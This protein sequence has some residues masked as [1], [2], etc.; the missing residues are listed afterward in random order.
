MSNNF[1]LKKTIR[2]LVSLLLFSFLLY[3]LLYLSTGDPALGV[4]QKMGGQNISKKMIEETRTKLGING[5]FLQQ[6]FRWLFSILKGDFGNSFITNV[7]VIQVINEKIWVTTKLLSL[8]FFF[9]FLVSITFGSI[10]GNFSPL[11]WVKQV[12]SIVLS[13]PIYWIAIFSIFLLGVKFRWFPFVGSST[14]L[15]LILPILVICL[16]EGSYLTK[17][18]SDLI[19]LVRKSERQKIAIFRGINWYYRFYYQLKEIVIP[20][21][22]LYGNSFIHLFG[23]TIMIEI[24]FSISG[25]GKLLMEAISARDYPVIQ[26]VTLLIAFGTFLFNYLIDIVIQ[27]ADARIQ[28]NGESKL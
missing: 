28:V 18:V 15:H 21:I 20:L 25:I 3:G 2:L 23:G 17:M 12:L 16:S 22:S 7:P 24:I 27:K 11:I 13:F 19:L 1:L 8:S 5:S 10:I 6:Y 14:N 9:C 4:L 26:G